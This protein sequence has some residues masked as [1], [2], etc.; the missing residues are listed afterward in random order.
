MSIPREITNRIR[1]ILDNYVPPIIRDSYW[2]MYPIAWIV[3]GKHASIFLQ[4]R[5]RVHGYSIREYDA[6]YKTVNPLF[7]RETDLTLTAVSYIENRILGTTVLEV[8]S[9]RGFL[10]KRL[11]QKYQVT[12]MDID[13][14]ARLTHTHNI[15]TRVGHV[16]DIPYNNRS[17]DTV[18]CTHTLEHIVEF[19][20]AVAELRRVAKKRLI[21]VVPMQRPY[22]YS[23]DLHVQFFPYTTSLIT[24]LSPGRNTRYICK[25]IDGDVYYE[26]D[27]K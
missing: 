14:D 21:I 19:Q 24:A 2:F 26:E 3:F 16:E 27:L 1:Y 5:D 9:G 6:I 12:A 22:R 25:A 10:A 11:A 17:I 18:V 20:M 23:L 15:R 8:G 7:S 13:I 4:F